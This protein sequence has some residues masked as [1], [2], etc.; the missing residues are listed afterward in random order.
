MKQRF[1]LFLGTCTSIVALFVG[2]DA[3][4]AQVTVAAGYTPPDDN[5]SVKVGGTIY[6]NY[7]YTQEPRIKDGDGNLVHQ[8]A[9][10]LT[11]AYINVTG[12][13]NSLISFRITPDVVR[14]GS[15]TVGDNKPVD[16]PGLTGTLTYRLKYAYGQFN[17]DGI[18]GPHGPW[19]AQGDW[20]RLGMQQTPIVD[21][22][23]Q[24]YRYR[25][26][27]Q[28]FIEREGFLTSS[29]LGGSAHWN[30]PD[31]YGDIHVGY[32]NGE[33]YTRAELNNTKAFQI[34]GTLRPAPDVAILKGLR[35]TGFYDHDEYVR[36]AK[37]LRYVG[38]LTF[39]N[40]YLNAGFDYLYAQDQ[41]ASAT[42]PIL[43]GE[44][45]SVWA[46]PRTP[47][48][49]EALIRFDYFRPDLGS[50]KRKQ[51]LIVG[52]AYWFKTIKGV[53]ASVLL[54]YEQVKY[55]RYNPK[56]PTEERYGIYTLFNF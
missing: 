17:L 28:I 7:E 49:L 3:G 24:I 8:N 47:F 5:P 43:K 18:G 33:G 31:N 51:R 12:Q 54:G 26:Q 40:P 23:E 56:L 53:A 2:A 52:P 38:Q 14:V 15:V 27:G 16:V 22:E 10:N 1:G 42:K 45:Y 25:Y 13:I 4:L 41:N 35:L 34:R 21:Y 44:G 37:K 30:F 48:G 6:A 9:F 32:Y 39:E 11:R 55:T 50:S 36:D 46:T 20:I 29:D 19:L